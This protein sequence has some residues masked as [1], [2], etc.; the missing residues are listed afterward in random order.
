[1]QPTNFL[2]SF[3]QNNADPSIYFQNLVAKLNKLNHYEWYNR[4]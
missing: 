2:S 4:R 3:K 1:M